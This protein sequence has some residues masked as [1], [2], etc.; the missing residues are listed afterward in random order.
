VTV[1]ESSGGYS[2]R[3][4]HGR[5]AHELGAR[6]VDQTY[7]PGD[8]LPNE[9]ELGRRMQASRTVVREAI[10]VL[11]GKGLLET[12]TRVGSRVLPRS[13]WNT[14]DPDILSWGGGGGPTSEFIR[15][16]FEFRRIIEPAAAALAAERGTP[17]RVAVITAAFGEMEA[18][19]EDVEAGVEPDLRFHLAVIAAS[20]NT[21]MNPLAGMIRSALS[22]SFRLATRPGKLASLPMHGDILEAIQEGDPGRARAAMERLLSAA[23]EDVIAQTGPTPAPGDPAPNTPAEVRR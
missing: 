5:I 17:E 20:D 6:I 2:R 13:H 18:A 22:F 7:R 16:L 11:A 1:R 8:V 15:D 19:G 14:L 9:A 21:L 3:N 23:H 12:R 4:L 10:K